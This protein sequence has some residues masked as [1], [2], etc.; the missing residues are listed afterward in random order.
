MTDARFDPDDRI[1][2]YIAAFEGLT[3]ENLS[4]L[5]RLC[6]WD[7]HFRDPFNDVHG[8][9]QFRAVF[10]KMFADVAAPSFQVRHWA[11]S[12]ATAYLRWTFTFQ[13]RRGRTVWRIEGMSEVTLNDEGLVAAHIDHWDAAGQLY[14]RLPLIGPVLRGLR[15]RLALPAPGR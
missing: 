12:G 14:E 7:V 6:A 5:V 13:P 9:A 15:R 8:A 10:E 3:P 2:A 4:A 1:R 11:R